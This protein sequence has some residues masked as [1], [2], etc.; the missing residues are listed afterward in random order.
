MSS[1][2]TIPVP[3]VGT[4]LVDLKTG[5]VTLAWQNYLISKAAANQPYLTVGDVVP[6]LPNAVS[7]GAL[8]SGFLSIT[9]IDDTATPSAGP[10]DP[11]S[12]T[13]VALSKVNDTNVTL[14]LG[15]T[16]TEALLRTVSL[17]LGWLGQLAAG[18]G[19]TGLDSSASTGV[20]QIAAG[21]WAITTT[22]QS[23][24]QDNITRVGTLVAGA[25]G[26]GFTIAIG[27][28]T[29]TGD[30][31]FSNLTQGSALSVLGVTGNATADMASIAAGSDHQVLRRSG[32]ALTFGAVN[33]AQSSAVT[34][35][36]AKANGGTSVDIDSAALPLGSGQIT[37]PATQN[38]ST[39][40]NTLDDYEEGT[41]TPAITFATPGD[42]N[43]VY[44]TQFG[45]YTKIGKL[46]RVNYRVIT[47]TFT[48]TTA[49]GALQMTGLPFTSQTT[50]GN[51]HGGALIYSQLT[52]TAGFNGFVARIVNNVTLVDFL[53]VGTAINTA[54][55]T[56]ASALT[57]TQKVLIGTIVYEATA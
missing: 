16:P 54:V 35:L 23:A 20:A 49:A 25:T 9:V 5:L 57:A 30:L 36:L 43:V 32:T 31:A 7:L 18:R 8:T 21:V 24:V 56:I 14:T 47:S 39:D 46:V 44:S 50:G 6:E 55:A 1:V 26:G 17:T 45:H 40:A 28:S 10:I 15:G 42:L 51:E 41:W 11:A 37:F 12:I 19:G 53:Q 48:H 22:L 33:L 4:P 38:P 3:P 34:G 13:G 27:T 29:V 2:P 52:Q